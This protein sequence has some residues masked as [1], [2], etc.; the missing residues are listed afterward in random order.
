VSFVHVLETRLAF[1][2]RLS[3]AGWLLQLLQLLMLLNPVAGEEVRGG[4]DRRGDI[5]VGRTAANSR[6]DGL[7]IICKVSVVHVK[8]KLDRLLRAQHA[9]FLKQ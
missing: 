6:F 5:E 4:N 7:G 8:D 9:G 3:L 2:Y 1:R